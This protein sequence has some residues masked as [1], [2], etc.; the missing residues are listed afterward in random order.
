MH[1]NSDRAPGGTASR[2]AWMVVGVLAAIGVAV[3]ASWVPSGDPASSVC[4]S[5]RVFGFTCPTCGMTRAAAALARGEV[6]EATRFHP[7]VVPLALEAVAVWIAWGWFAW[8]RAPAPPGRWLVRLVLGN[9][10]VFVIVWLLR[11]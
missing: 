7:L 5:R 1:T 3:L 6:A 10:V 9:V 2:T 4:V 11:I 8:R